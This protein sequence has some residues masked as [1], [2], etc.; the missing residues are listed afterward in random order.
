MSPPKY[1]GNIH[2]DEW[3]N[4]FQNYFNLKKKLDA[5]D[6][7]DYAISLVDPIIKLPTGIDDFEKLRKALKDDI[8]FTIFKN[9]NQRKLQL[10]KFIPESEVGETSKFI[11]NFRK[12][13][14]NAEINDIEEQ[15]NYFYLTLRN[16]YISNEFYK[17]MK[18]IKSTNELIEKFDKN[19]FINESNLIRKGSTIALKHVTTGKYLSSI[20]GLNYTT[21]SK[22]QLVFVN[23]LLNSDALWNI[24]FTSGRE[25]ASYSDTYIYLQHKSSSNFLGIFYNRYIDNQSPV[26]E[27]T[28][29]CCYSQDLWKFNISKLEND[30][31]YFKS[32]DIINISV[33]NRYNQ[34]LFLRSHDFNFTIGNDT[35]QEVACHSERL[36]GNDETSDLTGV[37]FI[38]DIKATVN[39]K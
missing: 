31:G 33:I 28:E 36:D 9:T 1:D 19:I 24:T 17:K 14:Y 37:L 3:I 34:Q 6:Y 22:A 20:R 35:F 39:L 7:L 23:D 30:Q 5:D 18:N 8:S 29:V 12:L 25:L 21:G 15:K 10:L 38:V 32:N 16:D 4:D 2:P 26:T 13:C 11:S 27:H